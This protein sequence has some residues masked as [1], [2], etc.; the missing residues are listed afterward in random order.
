MPSISLSDL[1]KEAEK[2]GSVVVPQKHTQNPNNVVTVT[3][4]QMAEKINVNAPKEELKNPPVVDI[5]F[6]SL[7]ATV[8]DIKRGSEVVAER[9]RE[10]AEEKAYEEFEKELTGDAIE[11]TS[12]KKDDLEIGEEEYETVS[13]KDVEREVS[14]YNLNASVVDTNTSPDEVKTTVEDKKDEEEPTEIKI[15]DFD[16]LLHELEDDDYVSTDGDDDFENEEEDAD[17][18][19]Q[20]MADTVDKEI[21]GKLF[22]NKFDPT[23]LKISKKP[24]SISIALNYHT[25]TKSTADFP[26]YYTQHCSKFKECTGTELQTLQTKID[27]SNEMSSVIEAVKFN[28]DHIVDPNKPAT[29]EAWAKMVRTEDVEAMYFGVYKATYYSSNLMPVTCTHCNT[30]NLV[31]VPVNDMVKPANDDVKAEMDKLFQQDTTFPYPE[32][33]SE[34]IQVSDRLFA[35]I[36]PPSIYDA[37]VQFSSIS[38][39]NQRKFQLILNLISCIETFYFLTDEG[40][41]SPIIIKTDPTNIRKTVTR[42]VKDYGSLIKGLTADQYATFITKINSLMED[43]KVSFIIP[44]VECPKCHKKIPAQPINSMLQILFTRAQL[45]QIKNT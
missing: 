2:K 21:R 9:N 11:E 44:E 20:R 34:L 18:V 14:S 13:Y 45:A 32:V 7:A 31:K 39:E 1:T 29:F 26:L 3:P 12:A 17:E 23:K 41:L 15:D 35:A 25:T 22:V 37:F 16:D 27:A 5:G 30:S 6:G 40:E 8:E 19:R 38:P 43:P 36:K 28:Y 33:K 42:K 24:T 4:S 10:A